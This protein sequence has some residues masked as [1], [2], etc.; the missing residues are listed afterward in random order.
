VAETCED[1]LGAKVKDEEE[2]DGDDAKEEEEAP[3]LKP[4]ACPEV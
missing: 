3:D 2:F 1:D 4:D